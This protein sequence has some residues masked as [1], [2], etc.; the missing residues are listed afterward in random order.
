MVSNKIVQLR[1]DV[2]FRVLRLFESPLD[3]SQ[4]EVAEKLGVSQG[5]IK[6]C[7]KALL[8]GKVN[9]KLANFKASPRRAN[10]ASNFFTPEGLAHCAVISAQVIERK[11]LEPEALKCDLPKVVTHV[12]C[13]RQFEGTSR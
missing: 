6:F 9:I 3:A 8:I 2:H 10:L 7:A 12:L 13:K 4:R 11:T 5:A 1:E